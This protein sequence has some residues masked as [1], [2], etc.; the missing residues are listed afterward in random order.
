MN[1]EMSTPVSNTELAYE[2]IRNAI[3]RQELKAGEA[4]S[5]VKLSEQLGIS[6]TP[7]REA[8]RLLERDGLVDAQHN[9]RVVISK[10]SVTDME[11]LYALR[12]SVESM[13]IRLAVPQLTAKDFGR[14]HRQ[15]ADMDR[16]MRLESVDDWELVHREFHMTLVRPAGPRIA[17]LIED[18]SD[19][20]ERY[21]RS[22]IAQGTRGWA[23]SS[24]EHKV[25][26]QAGEKGHV[27]EASVALAKH[28]ARVS[29]SV[30]LNQAPDHEPRAVRSALR[31]VVGDTR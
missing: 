29:L 7:L 5:Q 18:L 6:R 16:L 27:T 9:R 12:L 13:A 14:L 8:L 3:I 22:F 25:I 21:R 24:D 19:H 31:M 30:F 20:A 1:P 28:D 15:I 23:S 10:T 4:I 11:E 2:R 26:L 17:S